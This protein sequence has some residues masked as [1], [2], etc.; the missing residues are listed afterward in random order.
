MIKDPEFQKRLAMVVV[1]DAHLIVQWYKQFR[2]EY[3][4]LQYI[5]SLI[6]ERVPWLAC[7]T[8]LDQESL[9]IIKKLSYSEGRC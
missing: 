7:S 5:R 6:W 9:E 2:T 3:T 1:D 4:M 8:T